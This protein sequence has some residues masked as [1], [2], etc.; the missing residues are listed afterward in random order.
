M[1]PTPSSR[2]ATRASAQTEPARV[3]LVGAGPGDPDLL[4]RRAWQVLQQADVVLV[5]D[6]VQ[7]AVLHELPRRTRVL[8]VGKRGG[9]VS[10]DQAFIHTLMIREAQRGFKV[11]RLKGG[12]PFM[13]G[14]GGEECDA[15]RAAGL[16]VVVVPGITSGMAAPTS[17]G[18]PVTDRRH[19]P[20]VAF[21]TGHGQD[22]ASGPDWVA[23]VR[24]RLTLVVYMGVSKC[25]AIAQALL[26][27]GMAP[28]TACAVIASACT[29]KQR[30]AVGT[31]RGLA[32]MVRDHRLSSPAIIV[33]GD[34]AQAALALPSLA[35]KIKATATAGVM[36]ADALTG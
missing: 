22:G 10:T 19:A 2:D 4:T 16:E 23:L 7:D 12:D 20:G 9:C 31:V 34:V 8:H 33:V 13:F 29:P 6:L 17:I 25:E 32:A 3:W 28:D 26:E 30:H 18:V 27:G 21:V 35:A 1:K 15:L 11:V 24:S 36:H 14:R 5:D